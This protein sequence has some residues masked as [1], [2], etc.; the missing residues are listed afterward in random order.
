MD[1]LKEYWVGPVDVAAAQTRS[2]ADKDMID[3]F[4]QQLLK[5]FSGVILSRSGE[6]PVCSVADV[7][8][9]LGA[10]GT[11]QPGDPD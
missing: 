3:G 1:F 4:I 2:S 5:G 6:D 8:A 9:G 10:A 7:H 11:R